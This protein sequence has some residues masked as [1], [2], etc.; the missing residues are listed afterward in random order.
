MRGE[1]IP[2]LIAE[3][4]ELCVG[5]FAFVLNAL[6]ILGADLFG[7]VCDRFEVGGGL[8]LWWLGGVSVKCGLGTGG[9]GGRQEL[10]GRIEQ[11]EAQK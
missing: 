5:A 11:G 9:G 10:R 2:L 3:C 6:Q 7:D 8:H 4:A 1:C